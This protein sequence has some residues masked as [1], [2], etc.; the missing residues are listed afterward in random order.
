[1]FL[2]G[3]FDRILHYELVVLSFLTYEYSSSKGA[4]DN[5]E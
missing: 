1:M 4:E 3:S 5:F 2:N